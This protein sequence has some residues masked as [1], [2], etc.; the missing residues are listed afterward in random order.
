MVTIGSSID[1]PSLPYLDGPIWLDGWSEGD[2][3]WYYGIAT[4]GY[5]YNPGQQS[6]IAFFPSYPLTVRGARRR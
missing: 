4:Y 2:S 1:G 5:F 3:G 6:S